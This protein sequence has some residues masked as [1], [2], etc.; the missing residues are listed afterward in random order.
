MCMTS[1]NSTA[2]KLLWRVCRSWV[3]PSW[4]ALQMSCP[5][6]MGFFGFIKKQLDR[7]VPGHAAWGER[8]ERFKELLLVPAFIE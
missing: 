1:P 4:P 5:W 7:D 6:I 3:W 2:A 8:V